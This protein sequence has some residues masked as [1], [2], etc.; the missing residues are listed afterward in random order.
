MQVIQ[1]LPGKLEL[2]QAE[3][4]IVH[5]RGE[6]EIAAARQFPEEQLEFR[7]L[8]HVLG[9]IRL[10]HGQFIQVG[11]QSWMGGANGSRAVFRC[12]LRR[13]RFFDRRTRGL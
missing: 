8:G 9:V 10:G 4:Q 5:A 2:F 11:K 6:D 1:I 12:V 3:Q 13:G 7:R